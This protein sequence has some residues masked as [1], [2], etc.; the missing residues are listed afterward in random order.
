MVTGVGVAVGAGVAVGVDV[1]VC[2]AVVVG[3]AVAPGVGEVVTVGAAVGVGVGFTVRGCVPCVRAYTA[4]DE[5]AIMAIMA[6]AKYLIRFLRGALLVTGLALLVWVLRFVWWLGV[7]FFL[8]FFDK[9][10]CG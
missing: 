9:L 4:T 5:I 8:A 7:G 1:G 10:H 3:A 2:V 6:T